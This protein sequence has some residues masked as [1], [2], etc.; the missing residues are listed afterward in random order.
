MS[1]LAIVLTLL[2]LIAGAAAVAALAQA[3]KPAAPAFLTPLLRFLFV[4][5]LILA[6]NAVT[7]YLKANV[8]PIEKR[9]TLW[10]RFYFQYNQAA[11]A[12]LLGF[13]N[14]A[15]IL[16]I[17]RFLDRDLH[18]W[19]RLGFGLAW[20][21]LASVRIVASATRNQILG[22]G[23]DLAADFVLTS[24][25]LLAGALWL[26]FKTGRAPEGSG[27]AHLRRIARLLLAFVTVWLALRSAYLFHL[28]TG[29]V[30]FY[31]QTAMILGLFLF[32]LAHVRGLAAGAEDAAGF[33]GEPAGLPPFEAYGITEREKDI[34]RLI[35]EGKSNKEIQDRLF[36]SL[37]TVKDHVY[38]IYRKTGARNRVQLT[39]LF[40]GGSARPSGSRLPDA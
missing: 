39:N 17:G 26:F 10:I 21:A 7:F 37:Q 12:V 28:L 22:E 24:L 13:M 36:I 34:I 31:G 25:I 4:L 15:F 19:S 38:R 27:R 3:R 8:S 33:R 14:G 6:M 18:R 11:T 1:H 29:E 16:T 20:T 23:V 30:H 5:T 9:A 32:V 40:G 35:C 2:A